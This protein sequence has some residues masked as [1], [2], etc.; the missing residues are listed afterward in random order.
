MTARFSSRC[1]SCDIG[2]RTLD[3]ITLLYVEFNASACLACPA[4]K[5]GFDYELL[6]TTR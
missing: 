6:S 2:S 4:G 1:V 3:A 5:S